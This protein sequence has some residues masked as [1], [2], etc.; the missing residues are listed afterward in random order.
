MKVKIG[1]KV[2]DSANP[3]HSLGT[4]VFRALHIEVN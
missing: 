1:D 2:F 3:D 4:M